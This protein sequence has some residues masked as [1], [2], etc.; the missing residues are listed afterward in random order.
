MTSEAL[1][2]IGLYAGWRYG[3]DREKWNEEWQ[4]A[5]QSGAGTGGKLGT[6]QMGY[7]LPMALAAIAT[8]VGIHNGGLAA[9]EG[10][11]THYLGS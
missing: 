7:G 4:A 5:E 6:L 10:V 1:A 9:A 11:L 3:L 8:I 2:G